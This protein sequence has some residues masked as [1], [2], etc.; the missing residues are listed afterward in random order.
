MRH[1]EAG[2]KGDKSLGLLWLNY[3]TS[4]NFIN[5]YDDV[6]AL[7]G[8]SLQTF[9]EAEDELQGCCHN[10]G[11]TWWQ[12]QQGLERKSLDLNSVKEVKLVRFSN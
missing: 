4:A 5:T 3:I 9:L 2:T 8:S 6:S 11:M 7:P 10:L 12:G 1:R